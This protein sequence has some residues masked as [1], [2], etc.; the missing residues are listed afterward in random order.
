MDLPSCVLG[1][2]NRSIA[3]RTWKLGAHFNGALALLSP[4]HGSSG[5][6]WLFASNGQL[7]PHVRSCNADHE[8]RVQRWLPVCA[9][10]ARAG[11]AP[12][13]RP[14]HSVRS[15]LPERGCEDV[16]NFRGN[17]PED[18][19]LLVLGPALVLL[20]YTD[21]VD[22]GLP[23]GRYARRPFFSRL[24]VRPTVAGGVGA[25]VGAAAAARPARVSASL[26]GPPQQLRPA[27]DAVGRLGRIEKNWSPWVDA[28]DR[29]HVHQWLDRTGHSV[30]YAVNVSSGELEQR[31]SSPHRGAAA[32]PGG[33]QQ[34]LGVPPHT[35]VSGGTPAVRL[36]DTHHL[37]IGHTMTWRC[38]ALPEGAERARCA[39]RARWRSYAHFAYVF[40]SSPPFGLH[41]VTPAFRLRPPS[42]LATR[43]S[44]LLGTAVPTV[45]QHRLSAS[46]TQRAGREGGCVT[47]DCIQFPV[48]LVL[49]RPRRMALLS[50]GHRDQE[51]LLT[52]LA[53]HGDGG[54]LDRMVAA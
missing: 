15:A 53:L 52:W 48:G 27:S 36:N 28:R 16:V 12:R 41:A 5:A 32:A 13:T 30:V 26:L 9:G 38:L 4:L 51:T 43:A 25:S 39:R 6:A 14:L 20:L 44:G 45:H 49:D 37:A 19:R 35:I 24:A 40:S 23:S 54:L 33:L 42:R 3:A 18:G 7:R 29:V 8:V 2:V 1:S 22:V 10:G 47:V 46:A 31:F 50:W 21:Y 11:G 17:G 34:L